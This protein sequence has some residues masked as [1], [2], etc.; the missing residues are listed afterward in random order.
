MRNATF[1]GQHPV[2]FGQQVSYW[3]GHRSTSPVVLGPGLVCVLLAVLAAWG[4]A[5][6]AMRPRRPRAHD[7][8]TA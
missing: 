5:T 2:R 4:I 1:T 7:E 6:L 3:L 8:H